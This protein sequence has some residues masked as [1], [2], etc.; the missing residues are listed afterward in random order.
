TCGVPVV[1]YRAE[2][3][4]ALFSRNSGLALQLSADS[5]A[6]LAKLLKAQ[7]ELNLKSSIVIAN[8]IPEAFEMEY[9]AINQV[10]EKALEE[11]TAKNIKGKAITPFL[12]SRVEQLTA[13]KSLEANIQLVYN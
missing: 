8:P 11:A 5:P 13:G 7:E 9:A 12:L 2:E 10:I 3:F 4:P 6:E 1:G